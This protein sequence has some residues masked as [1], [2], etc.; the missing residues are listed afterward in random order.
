MK[1]F[2]SGASPYVRKCM[3]VAHEL[4]LAARIEHL[5]AAAHPVN[6]DQN[7]VRNNPLGKV[8]TLLTDDGVAL[9]DSRVICEYLN[10][11]GAGSLF[12][13]AGAQR[14]Q[15]LTE[16]SLGDGILDAALLARYESAMRPEALRWAD[17]TN[18]QLD[19]IHCGL[20]AIDARADSLGERVDIGTLTMGCVLGYLD[21]RFDHLGWR[22]KHAR[23]A[24]WFARFN[25][26]PAMQATLPKA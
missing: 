13:A 2:Y 23:A 26:R 21:L 4:G 1:L 18:G 14:W 7:I 3:V 22:Q 5:P 9:Y 24:A 11:L 17:W 25:A 15:S 10:D 6:R 12:P 19:K 16:Q 20:A 8:P